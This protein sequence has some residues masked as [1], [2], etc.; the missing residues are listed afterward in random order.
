[1]CVVAPNDFMFTFANKKP[2]TQLYTL[3]EI[4]LGFYF[5]FGAHVKNFSFFFLDLIF[6]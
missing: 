4:K 3:N 1:M 6:N 5:S 2:T